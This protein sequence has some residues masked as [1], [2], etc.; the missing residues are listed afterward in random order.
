MDMKR[1]DSP[2]RAADSI[3]Q[4]LE[5]QIRSGALPDGEPLPAERA[6]MAVHQTSRTV[7]REAITTLT[8]RG[9]IEN[10]PRFRP[11]VRKPGLGAFIESTRSV[12][13]HLFEQASG[14]RQLYETRIFIE[15]QLV[16]DAATHARKEDIK[17]LSVALANNEAHIHDD[18]GF[19]RTDMEFHAVLY[20]IP[21]NP[22][23]TALHEAYREW[24]DTHWAKMIRSPERNYVN[25]R[26]HAEIYNAI[27]E[28]DPDAAEIAM[29]THLNS[30]WEYLRVLMDED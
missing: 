2:A 23:F 5:Q 24:L 3:V 8:S 21:K 12:T 26:C 9:L 16:R 11:I 17:A 28:R 29:S 20:D 30:A 13:E 4:S 14:V 25:Y 10:R 18:K 15:R 19:Y 6:L 7:V 22:I 1:T 27:V